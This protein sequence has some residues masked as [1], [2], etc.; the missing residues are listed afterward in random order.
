MGMGSG[1]TTW[2]DDASSAEMAEWTEQEWEWFEMGPFDGGIPGLV[3]R[4]RRILEVSQRGLAAL[5]DVSQSVVARWETGRTSPRACVL[6]ELLRMAGLTV[7]YR[8]EETGE[9]VTPMRDDGAR[10]HGGSRFPAHA[11]LRATGWWTPRPLMTTM[12]EYHRARDRSRA[13][14]DPSIRATT[15][16]F[17]RRLLRLVHGTP[18][19]HPSVWQ[20]AAEAEHLDERREERLGVPVR[21]R[22]RPRERAT[23]LTA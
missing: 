2:R 5:I 18:D 23:S 19:D 17:W 15:C 7:T 11:D 9:E 6:H 22:A 8:D 10:T 12:V 4:V 14:R 1:S 16:P 21:H 13:R 20:L 3:R